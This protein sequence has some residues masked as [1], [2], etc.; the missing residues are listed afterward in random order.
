[1][2][3]A[4]CAL[5]RPFILP[6]GTPSPSSTQLA[7]STKGSGP[8]RT[9]GLERYAFPNDGKFAFTWE[10]LPGSVIAADCPAREMAGKA[11]SQVQHRPI[12][13]G[14]GPAVGEALALKLAVPA[15]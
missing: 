14:V 8:A 10:M 9:T 13:H 12:G 3:C 7:C 2:D 15:R 11:C 1:M 5:R 6:P 4:P